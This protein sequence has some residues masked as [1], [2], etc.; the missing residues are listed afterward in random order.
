MIVPVSFEPSVDMD[1]RTGERTFS[2][3]LEVDAKLVRYRWKRVPR[4]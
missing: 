2:G 3:F 1:L 4:S